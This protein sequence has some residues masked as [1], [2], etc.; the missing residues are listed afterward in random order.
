M[1][2]PNNKLLFEKIKAGNAA[3]ILIIVIAALFL[4]SLIFTSIPE[5]NRDFVLILGGAFFATLNGAVYFL[6][7]YKKS[8]NDGDFRARYDREICDSCPHKNSPL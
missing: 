3:A 8:S 4:G 6:F 5:G 1:E 2:Q 7:N